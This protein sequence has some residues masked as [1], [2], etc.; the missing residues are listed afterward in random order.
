MSWP[1]SIA[2]AL[3]TGLIYSVMAVGIVL[4]YRTSR[5]LAF[6]MGEV[7]MLAA[8]VLVSVWRPGAGLA[9]LAA[10]I[11]AA[12]GIAAL[13][14]VAMYLL[15]ERLGGRFGH[16]VGTVI[17]IA[18]TIALHGIMS[19][20]WGAQTWRMPL[21]EGSISW[22][23]MTFPA[24]NI[25]VLVF[26]AVILAIVVL[27]ITRTTIGIDMQAI[28]CNPVLARLRGISVQRTLCVV[29]V[30]ATLLAAISGILIASVSVVS[31]EG[32]II[33]VSAIVAALIG[34]MTSIPFAIVGA[35]LLAACETLVTL[36]GEPRYSQVIPVIGLMLLL[37]VRPTGLASQSEH[38][39]RV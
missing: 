27:V 31:L 17:T 28:A 14:G 36:F 8:Y 2:T 11:S 20:I 10:A 35:L 24:G 18:A 33:G 21:I 9:N 37:V 26:S 16:F 32:A 34:G 23:G 1:V 7:G 4:I 29:W 6:H 30:L 19:L 13:A 15:V 25:A 3:A 22:L 38:I 12:L 39:A 5:V